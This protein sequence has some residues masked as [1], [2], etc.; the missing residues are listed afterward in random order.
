MKSLIIDFFC[1]IIAFFFRCIACNLLAIFESSIEFFFIFL[2]RF[3][4]VVATDFCVLLKDCLPM[5]IML[6]DD[7]NLLL[8]VVVVVLFFSSHL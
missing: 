1:L 2:E 7:V 8:F 4:A 6:S 5:I 3:N